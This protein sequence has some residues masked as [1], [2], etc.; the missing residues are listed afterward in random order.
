MKRLL[1]SGLGLAAVA[2]V[3]APTASAQHVSVGITVHAPPVVLDLA[4]GDRGYRPGIVVVG[5]ARP[6]RHVTRVVHVHR[7]VKHVV[8]HK[9][10][11]PHRC[12]GLHTHGKHG[13]HK[14]HR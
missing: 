9:H 1:V 6:H 5:H 4:Y 10:H 13:R 7:P 11:H 2:V 14:G 3:Y 8:V 12:S